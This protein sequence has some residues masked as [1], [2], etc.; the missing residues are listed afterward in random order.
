MLPEE[1]FVEVS[2]SAQPVGR[3]TCRPHFLEDAL[4]YLRPGRT[5]LLRDV[6]HWYDHHQQLGIGERTTVTDFYG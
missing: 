4:L 2:V 5:Q 1:L 6:H 3:H